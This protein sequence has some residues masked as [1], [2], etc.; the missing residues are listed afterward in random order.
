MQQVKAG[1]ATNTPRPAAKGPVFLRAFASHERQFVTGLFES[2]GRDGAKT[3]S[4]LVSAV[5]SECQRHLL[6]TSDF[7]TRQTANKCLNRIDQMPQFAISF[8]SSIL[9]DL[10]AQIGKGGQ[11]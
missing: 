10:A 9:D 4:G 8:A 6:N 11:A 1:Q 2:A 7:F 3:A 5:R